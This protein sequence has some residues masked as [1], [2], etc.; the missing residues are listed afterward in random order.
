MQFLGMEEKP[1]ACGKRDIYFHCSPEEDIEI[2]EEV[3]A[4]Q[5]DWCIALIGYSLKI[6]YTKK[7]KPKEGEPKPALPP[8]KKKKSKEGEPKEGEPKEGEPKPALPPGKNSGFLKVFCNSVVNSWNIPNDRS[9]ILGLIPI[10][11]RIKN[12]S[13]ACFLT[14]P[15]YI[16]F[17]RLSGTRLRFSIE[18]NTKARDV[19][20]VVRI[21]PSRT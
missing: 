21:T 3:V 9:P 12:N 13:Y 15:I 18:Q 10:D 14:N 6:Q 8:G 19:I 7:K 20:L 2:P 17:S 16:P 1:A 5:K 11:Q 4:D